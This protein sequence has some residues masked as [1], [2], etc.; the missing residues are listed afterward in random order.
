MLI[1]RYT[2][3][4]ILAQVPE[5]ARHTDPVLVQIDHVLDDDVVF[6]QVRADLGRRYPR[7]TRWGR[8]STPVEV[9]LRM[10]AVKRLYNWSYEETERY[11]ADSFVLRWFCRVYW[12]RVPDDTTLLRW[13]RLIPA[14]TLQA[15]NERVVELAHQARVTHGR[16]LRLDGMVVPT[17]IHHPTDS[18][19][20]TD[21]VRV[22]SRLIR[23]SKPLVGEQL[24]GVR[25]AFR[26]RLRTMRRALQAIHRTAR[27]AG[28]AAAEQRRAVYAK[29]VDTAQQT[30]QQAER[31]RQALDET[32]DQAQRAASRLRE[33]L[34]RFVPRVRQV[35][36]QARRRVLD[37]QKV[38]AEEKIVS[39][40][41]PHTRVI[42]RHKGGADVEFGRMVVIDEV[43]G[44][45][46][47]RYH[48]LEDGAT[49][50]GEL[51]PALRQHQKVFG[52]PPTLAT[53]DRGFHAPDNARLAREAGVK[54]LVIPS[55][56][57]TTAEQRAREKERGWRRRYRWRAGIE[58]RINSLDRDY[59]L[60]RCA[61]HGADGL[62]RCVGWGILAS[63]LCHIGQALAARQGRGQQRA[64]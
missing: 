30:V 53:A 39:L 51:A 19:L 16:K 57:K 59:G 44:G 46:V 27:Q 64:A 22:L 23:R 48:L 41:E 3:E 20:L 37:G 32:A 5:T 43:E 42:R 28:E 45:L 11:V 15:L 18:S 62:D 58:G 25:D 38:P 8:P 33:H 1:D 9:I 34:D 17:A 31:V 54:H 63:N 49:E 60:G 4:D 13:A 24:A 40:F 36:H 14:P 35:I 56:G 7:T 47:T 50:H 6:Q 10:L 26:T 12:Q 61:D 52:H 21:G 29:M 55:G 2:R